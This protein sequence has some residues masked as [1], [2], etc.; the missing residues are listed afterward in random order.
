[1]L[2]SWREILSRAG[3]GQTRPRPV[4]G[5]EPGSGQASPAA[6]YCELRDAGLEA[7]AAGDFGKAISR[8]SAAAVIRRGLPEA[9]VNLARALRAGGKLEAARQAL[10]AALGVARDSAADIQRELRDLP[11]PPRMD[12][13]HSTLGI[14]HR[15]IKSSNCLITA[16][17]AAKI[18]DFGLARAFSEWR[19]S[20]LD[21][22]GIDASIRRHP[23]VCPRGEVYPMSFIRLLVVECC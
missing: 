5:D 8:L 20:A 9:H 2:D 12:F 16:A 6:R 1:M 14:V 22:P 10:R 21:A 17:G 3:W 7:L 13:A 23:A 4:V 19:V 18:G 11:E 15:D